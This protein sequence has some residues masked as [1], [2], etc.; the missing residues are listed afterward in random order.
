MSDSDLPT[1]GFVGEKE[2]TIPRI[3]PLPV[4]SARDVATMGLQYGPLTGILIYLLYTLYVPLRVPRIS[5][6]G[7]RARAPRSEALNPKPQCSKGLLQDDVP[8]VT[9]GAV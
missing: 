6:K 5:L 8:I 9:L 3:R 4:I 2:D 7:L 1:V